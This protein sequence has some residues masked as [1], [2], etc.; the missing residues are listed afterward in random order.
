MTDFRKL[1]KARRQAAHRA[2]LDGGKWAIVRLT[3]RYEVRPY[4]RA[5]NL[6]M[7]HVDAELVEVVEGA[8]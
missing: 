7:K 2:S 1:E 3:D 6:V 5:R 4:R 8:A